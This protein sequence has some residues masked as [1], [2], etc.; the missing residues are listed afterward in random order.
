MNHYLEAIERIR[1]AYHSLKHV[2]PE[3]GLVKMVK[4]A[5]SGGVIFLDEFWDKYPE[6]SF[7]KQVHA[8]A[9]YACDLE[10]EVINIS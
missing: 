6:E 5:S 7:P 4:W 1:E 3:N 2:S 9:Q 10:A 8:F